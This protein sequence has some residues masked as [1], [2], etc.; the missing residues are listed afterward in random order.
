MKACKTWGDVSEEDKHTW[1]GLDVAHARLLE[2]VRSALSLLTALI[3]KDTTSWTQL[4]T[5]RIIGRWIVSN[6]MKSISSLIHIS[7]QVEIY[8]NCSCRS[9]LCGHSQLCWRQIEFCLTLEELVEGLPAEYWL[10]CHHLQ[11]SS[12][13]TCIPQTL[14]ACRTPVM[15]ATE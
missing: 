4:Q 11:T 9:A 14:T 13:G 10:A 7:G 15:N 12:H 5:P 8:Y 2:H 3:C 6:R 1:V